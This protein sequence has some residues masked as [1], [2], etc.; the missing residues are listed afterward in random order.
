[1]KLHCLLQNISIMCKDP[2]TEWKHSNVVPI[3][4]KNNA[5]SIIDYR[6]I[7]LL[8]I[9]SL[10]VEQR[11]C[12]EC[13]VV[14]DEVHFLCDCVRYSSLRE[15]L[16]SIAIPYF[17]EFSRPTSREKFIFLLQTEYTC[18][19]KAIGSFVHKAFKLYH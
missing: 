18:I 19:L 12:S 16:F 13:G 15:D 17:P 8:P 9:I 6:P 14:E 5:T 4:K 1:M 3:P 2:P 10:P 7:S 11:L